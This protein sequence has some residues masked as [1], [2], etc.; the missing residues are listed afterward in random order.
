MA[1]GRS[2]SGY[3]SGQV[4]PGT[5]FRSGRTGQR[6]PSCQSACERTRWPYRA[7][8]RDL[9]NRRHSRTSARSQWEFQRQQ[10]ACAG[11]RRS[12][13]RELPPRI[14][15][16]CRRRRLADGRPASARLHD[17]RDG[18][19]HE[20]GSFR[21]AGGSVRWAGGLV[22]GYTPNP[23]RSRHYVRRRSAPDDS[24]RKICNPTAVPD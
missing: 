1:G 22:R 2:R 11:I 16:A 19:L 20:P 9:W 7:C 10:G 15:K 13:E 21:G 23:S 14:K 4:R 24:R 6:H 12:A 18:C 3:S 5:G 17:K 8:V